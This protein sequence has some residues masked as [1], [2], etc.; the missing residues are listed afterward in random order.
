MA[1]IPLAGQT[2]TFSRASKIFGGLTPEELGSYMKAVPGLD[3]NTLFQTVALGNL[4]SPDGGRSEQERIAQ[5]QR[6]EARWNRML[7]AQDARQLAQAKERQKLGEESTQKTLLYKML[8]DLP[9]N[10]ISAYTLPAA[11]QAEGAR[12]IADMSLQAGRNIAATPVFQPFG[13]NYSFNRYY[14]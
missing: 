5:E 3:P 8:S 7:D 1:D 14:R 4:I 6:E 9:Q 12:N 2:D 11:I 13:Q 10:I